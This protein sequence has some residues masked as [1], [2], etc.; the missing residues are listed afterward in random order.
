MLMPSF[1][2]IPVGVQSNITVGEI[3]S[4]PSSL[5][6]G[7]TFDIGAKV[8]N[9]SPHNITF[10]EGPCD[11]PMSI[12]LD[13]HVVEGS[14]IRCYAPGFVFSLLSEHSALIRGPTSGISLKAVKMGTTDGNLVFH[15]RINTNNTFL[16]KEVIKSFKFFIHN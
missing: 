14:E 6:V 11:S 9:N 13:D 3:R 10:F 1:S 5:R 12:K 2:L 8:L 15:F 4:I 16:E 7:D